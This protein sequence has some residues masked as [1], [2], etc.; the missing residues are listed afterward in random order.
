[1]LDQMTEVVETSYNFLN[2]II[3][4]LLGAFGGVVKT[5]QESKED[6]SK[7]TSFRLLCNVCMSG[8][9][10][11]LVSFLLQDVNIADGLKTFL[12]G[13]CGWSGTGI[14][15]LAVKLIETYFAGRAGEKQN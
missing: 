8:F 9:T 13:V 11:L 1:M 12:I 4:L 14:L 7:F 5:I 6:K 2:I 10:A 15:S 3:S